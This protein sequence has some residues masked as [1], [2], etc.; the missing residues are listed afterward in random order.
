MWWFCLRHMRVESEDGCANAERLGPYDTEAEAADAL[1][2]A[3]ER[4]AQEDARD[5][6]WGDSS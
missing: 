2:R 3:K 6:A 4:T 1:N 5:K